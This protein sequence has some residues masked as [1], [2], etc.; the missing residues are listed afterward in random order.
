MNILTAP[1]EKSIKPDK[2]EERDPGTAGRP[3]NWGDQ[4]R[5]QIRQGPTEVNVL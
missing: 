5:H 4:K 2:G 1:N 3:Q